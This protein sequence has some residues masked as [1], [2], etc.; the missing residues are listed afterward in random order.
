MP[1]VLQSFPKKSN[2]PE[3]SSKTEIENFII[4]F[5]PRFGPKERPE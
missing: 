5:G 4:P 1:E 3:F 2:E